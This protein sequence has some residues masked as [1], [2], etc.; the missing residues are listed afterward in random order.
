MAKKIA[1]KKAKKKAKTKKVQPIPSN[2]SNVIPCFRVANCARAIDFITSV[3]GA[4]I[5]DRYDG[6][7][8]EV[9]HCEMQLGDTTL[10]C[11]E[12]QPGDAQ[13]LAASIY[14]KDCD[15]VFNK[16]VGLGARVKQPLTNQFYGDRV[17]RVVDAHGNEWMIA[18][19][20]EDVSKKEMERRM[21]AQPE[22]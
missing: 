21:A 7:N 9:F 13:T 22:G 4:K 16:A 8:G 3:F 1:K 2:Y 6:P 15:A 18:T 11:G 20:I 10:M 17:G 14:V 19:H 5:R 12:A